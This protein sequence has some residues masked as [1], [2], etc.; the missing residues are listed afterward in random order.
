MAK[1]VS[2]VVERGL[3]FLKESAILCFTFMT[4]EVDG[5]ISQELFGGYAGCD[6]CK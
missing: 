3:N 6:F 2:V 4:I 5:K 1:Q